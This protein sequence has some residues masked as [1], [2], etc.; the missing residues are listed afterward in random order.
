MSF[1]FDLASVRAKANGVPTP[2]RLFVR[3]IVSAVEAPKVTQMS[4]TEVY[5][6]GLPYAFYLIT[7]RLTVC[8]FFGSFFVRLSVLP[9][10]I[11]HPIF[12]ISMALRTRLPNHLVPNDNFHC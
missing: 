1:L 3:L 6:F 9:L 7:E 2:N 4:T 11:T 8:P 12:D 10:Q 5:V